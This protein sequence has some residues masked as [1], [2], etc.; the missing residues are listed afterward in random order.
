MQSEIQSCTNFLLDE[1]KYKHPKLIFCFG[2]TAVLS[3]AQIFFPHLVDN[4]FRITD[5]HT[6]SG[7]EKFE[8]GGFEVIPLLHPSNANRFMD[9]KR[10]TDHL[11]EIYREYIIS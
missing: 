8:A 7:Y 9:Y 5:L 6:E 1:I 10:Y 4:N 3:L 2:R 11:Q